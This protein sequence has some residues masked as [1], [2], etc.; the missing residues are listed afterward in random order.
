[1]DDAAMVAGYVGSSGILDDAI[2]AF[3]VEYADQNRRD[4]TS[5]TKAVREQ[6]VTAT[7]DAWAER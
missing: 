2:G 4:F 5:F 6:R 1:M 7:T 3:A